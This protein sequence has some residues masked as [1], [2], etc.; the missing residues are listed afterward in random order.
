MSI[1]DQTVQCH[2][3]I[4]IE[5]LSTDSNAFITAI[6]L[7]IFNPLNKTDGMVREWVFDPWTEQPGAVI[8]SATV[9]WRQQQ[10]AA[11]K[12][13]LRGQANSYYDLGSS[14]NRIREYLREY[15]VKRVWANSPDFDLTII[16]NAA[17]RLGQKPVTA[18]YT[19]RCVRTAKDIM[20]R[21]TGNRI[22]LATQ[23]TALLD[24]HAQI[25]AVVIPFLKLEWAKDE[26]RADASSAGEGRSGSNITASDPLG[27]TER[28]N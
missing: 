3:M 7:V 24:C 14:L 27:S 1:I 21:L 28:S 16:N 10:D 8:D 22:K 11:S 6:G 19:H 20:E 2:A 18:Y 5:T 13:P 4:D 9:T 12:A 25:E 26:R 17:K 23:H 15:N